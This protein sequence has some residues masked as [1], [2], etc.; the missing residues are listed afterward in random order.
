MFRLP[1]AK[2]P[3]QGASLESMIAMIIAVQMGVAGGMLWYKIKLKRVKKR[4]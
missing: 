1:V 4:L 2:Q 3:D